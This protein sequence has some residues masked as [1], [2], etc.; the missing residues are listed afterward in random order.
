[1]NEALAFF[2]GNNSN[3]NFSSSTGLGSG[4]SSVGVSKFRSKKNSN[5]HMY[6]D[7]CN[8]T[9][10]TRDRC[11]KIH[12]YP[13]DWK[14]KKRIG[15][16]TANFGESTNSSGESSGKSSSGGNTSIYGVVPHTFMA[17]MQ[18]QHSS[19]PHPHFSH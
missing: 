15:P 14:G 13:S 5:S 3:R 8:W 4:G 10:H 7:Y 6:C 19:H 9:G 16:N 18:H 17:N 1:M 12:G 11:Y 2:S